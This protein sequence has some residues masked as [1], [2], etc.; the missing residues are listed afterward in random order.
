MWRA[1]VAG[2]DGAQLGYQSPAH[3]HWTF[4]IHGAYYHYDLGSING[5][6]AGDFRSNLRRADGYYLSDFRLANLLFG[7]TYT[8]LGERWPVRVLAD[9]VR[10]TGAATDADTGYGIDVF[11]GKTAGPGD[12]RFGY[13]YS[14]AQT[15]AVL[16]AFSHDNLRIAS[17]YRLHTF[18][19]D[20]VPL[21]NTAIN[22]IWYHY[23]PDSARDA[24]ANQPHDWLERLRLAFLVNF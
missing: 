14:M 12:W 9:L 8:G 15:D 2:G 17:N 3:G 19:M 21:P 4:D 10:N 7:S 13:G 22:L 5:A 23:R 6:D 16:A 18:S 11:L 24:G 1:G 20:Y